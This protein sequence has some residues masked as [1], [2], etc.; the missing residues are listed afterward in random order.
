M[1]FGTVATLQRCIFFLRFPAEIVETH[2]LPPLR[3]SGERSS[4]MASGVESF[5]CQL[6]VKSFPVLP[7]ARLSSAGT[8]NNAVVPFLE[9]TQLYVSCR[10]A[11]VQDVLKSSNRK[12]NS[13][14]RDAEPHQQPNCSFVRYALVS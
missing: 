9:L 6:R 14:G 13:R 8:S 7:V 5:S 4:R 11:A 1:Q 10:P 3:N 12:G 2:R